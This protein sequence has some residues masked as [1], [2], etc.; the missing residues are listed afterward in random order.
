MRNNHRILSGA[1][2]V[3][4]A[5]ACTASDLQRPA[6]DALT[7]VESPAGPHS[8]EPNL[9]V[10]A[11]GRVHLSWLERD[12]DSTVALRL[13]VRDDAQWSA[14]VTVTSRPDLFVNWADFP[15]VF[16]APSG[17][18]VMHWLQK[19]AGGKYSYDVMTRQSADGGTT[20]SEPR[21][22][23]DDNVAAE[24]GFVSFFA[25]DGDSVEAVWLDGR[26]TAGGD[27]DGHRGAMQLGNGRIAADGGVSASVMIDNRICDCCQ[28]SAAMTSHGPIVVYRDRSDQEIRDIAVVRRVDGQWTAPTHVHADEWH[29]EGCPVNGPSVAADGAN[30]VVAWFT[31]ARDTARV[32]VAFSSDAGATFGEP[33]RVDDG[34]PG[35]R[36]DVEYDGTGRA[37]VTW[38]ERVGDDGAEVRIKAVSPDRSITPHMVV[39]SSAAAR[40]SG[41]PRMVRSGQELV[42]AWT[43]PGD[44]ARVRMAVARVPGQGR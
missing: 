4:L 39:A 20:W 7:P 18:V 29:I 40:S 22:L 9:A 1:V 33:V 23:H 21:V 32:N 35:G 14:P 11:A 38:L 30:V 16:V 42:F 17:R 37:L 36:V 19:R 31:G 10:D 28:T 24:H 44:T 2:V 15:S 43:L 26:A 3:P 13:A 41:F 27:H 34:T 5:V 6:I 25:A 8:G 12:G